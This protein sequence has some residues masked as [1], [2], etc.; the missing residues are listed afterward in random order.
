[1]SSRFATVVAA[2]KENFDLVRIEMARA[3][4]VAE[5][6][7]VGRLAVRSNKAAPYVGW[8]RGPGTVLATSTANP[9]CGTDASG[10]S[11]TPLYDLQQGVRCVI[12]GLTEEDTEDL[13]FDVLLAVHRTLSVWARPRAFRWFTQEEEEAAYAFAGAELLMQDFEWPFVV[14]AERTSVVTIA[15]VTHEDLFVPINQG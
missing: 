8:V 4:L 12:C 15:T 1:V 7:L 11:I 9:L 14:P 13:W 10:V 6:W 2:V 5:K 3:P